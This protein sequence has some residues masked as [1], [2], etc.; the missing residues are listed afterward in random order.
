MIDL[1][2]WIYLDDMVDW[3][4]KKETFTVERQMNFFALPRTGRYMK[5]WRD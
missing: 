2:R 3:L 4:S 1:K 5:N